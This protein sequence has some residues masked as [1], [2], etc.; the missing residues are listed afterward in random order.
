MTGQIDDIILYRWLGDAPER[1]PLDLERLEALY[2]RLGEAAVQALHT[3][4]PLP[5]L[6][7]ELKKLSEARHRSQTC[8]TPA[9][10]QPESRDGKPSIPSRTD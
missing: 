9:V 2:Q 3:R 8:S 10:L 6:N 7:P 1:R 4:L 5:L